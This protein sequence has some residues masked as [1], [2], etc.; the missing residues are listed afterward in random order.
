[1]NN[2]RTITILRTG[3]VLDFDFQDKTVPTTKSITNKLLGISAR[4]LDG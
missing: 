2:I 1:M 3:A 4:S